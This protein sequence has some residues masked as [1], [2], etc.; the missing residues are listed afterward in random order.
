M[1]TDRANPDRE[2]QAGCA[3]DFAVIARIATK[4]FLMPA[5]S[6]LNDG[7]VMSPVPICEISY[8]PDTSCYGYRYRLHGREP[9]YALDTYRTLEVALA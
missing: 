5:P 8:V 6:E 3:G 9:H 4:G 2:P 7:C 1:V